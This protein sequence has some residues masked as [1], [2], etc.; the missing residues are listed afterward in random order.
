MDILNDLFKLKDDK[1]NEFN[2]SLINNLDKSKFIGVRT[3]MIKELAKKYIKDPYINDFLNDLPHK[4]HEENMLHGLIISEIKDYDEVLI[5][6]NQFLPYI[7]NWAVCDSLKIKIFKKNEDKLIN[8]IYKW[9]KSD[10]EYIIRYAIGL[11]MN[12]Y[13]K[14]KYKKEYLLLPLNVKVN[15]YYVN[16]MISWYYATSLINHYE[17]TL[18]VLINKL[19]NDFIFKKTISK[20]IESYRIDEDKKNYLRNLRE[21]NKKEL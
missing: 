7:D 4:Y 6:L 13:L 14:D 1:Y 16:M 10:K 5:K 17:D 12:H 15:T 9:L 18:D 21:K 3:P 19:N 20:A 11:L 8:E 2:S